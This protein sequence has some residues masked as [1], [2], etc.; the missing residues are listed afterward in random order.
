MYPELDSLSLSELQAQFR[1]APPEDP[2]LANVPPPEDPDLEYADLWYDEVAIAIRERD[3]DAGARFLRGEV[4]GADPDR[5]TAILLAIS[6]F[7]E[8]DRGN[9]DLLIECLA[10]PDEHVVARAIDGLGW[11]G[12][13][14][15]T[16]RV[17]ALIADPR[18][19]VRGAVLRFAARAVPDRAPSLLL[20]ALQDPH[21]HVRGNAVDQ[22]EDLDYTPALARIEALCVDPH[23]HVR[24]TALSAIANLGGRDR[25]VPLLL[26]ALKDPH[27]LV[28]E[29][30][31][32]ELDE[33]DHT[34]ALPRI[35]ALCADPHPDVRPAALSA[36][37]K[38]GGPEKAIP[39]L[40]DA[41]GD[42]DATVRFHAISHLGRL[43]QFTDRA[44]FERMLNDPDKDVRERARSAFSH[45][46][47]SA[48]PH[49]PN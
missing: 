22:L 43:E 25:A 12:G 18:A 26:D 49:E 46:P 9:A 47:D 24:E 28:R 30:A 11:L 3:P 21:Y 34:A 19:G 13:C 27:H 8:P 4:A 37:D 31:V 40:L 7:H 32:R 45:L 17:L 33:L 1:A 38:L 35:E 14:G 36:V 42:P 39:L 23:P 29:R 41:L 15:L 10:H 16:D 6:W 20:D 44:T 5:L 2:D 48:Q